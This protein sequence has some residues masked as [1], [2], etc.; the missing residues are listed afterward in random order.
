TR[1]APGSSGKG[2][3]YHVEVLP[4]EEFVTFQTQDV[5]RRGHIQRVAGKRSSG[6][7]TTVKWLIGKEDAHI[8]DEKLV[9]DTKAAKNVIQQLGSDPIRLVGDRFRAKPKPRV[10]ETLKPTFA[11]GR[12]RRE[13]VKKTDPNRRKKR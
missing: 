4:A 10:P 8:Q 5:G 7:W 13:S 3:Y 9:P 12:T 1:K 2:D 6:Y 11:E